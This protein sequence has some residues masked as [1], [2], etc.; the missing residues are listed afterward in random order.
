MI[1][2]TPWQRFLQK[3]AYLLWEADGRPEGKAD[4]FWHE[5]VASDKKM[6]ARWHENANRRASQASVPVETSRGVDR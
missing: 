1:A 6:R 3:K 5:A 4:E 2:S